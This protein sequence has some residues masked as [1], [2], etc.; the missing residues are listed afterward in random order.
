MHPGIFFR[1]DGTRLSGEIASVDGFPGEEGTVTLRLPNDEHV[2]LLLKEVT[3]PARSEILD[4]LGLVPRLR[5]TGVMKDS[6]AFRAGI[7]PE[8]IVLEYGGAPPLLHHRPDLE[9]HRQDPEQPVSSGFDKDA[10]GL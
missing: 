4:I 9:R 5:V 6:P 3:W 2:K 8:D 10:R 1:K 7:L